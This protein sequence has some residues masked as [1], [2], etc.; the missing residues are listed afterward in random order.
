MAKNKEIMKCS[1]IEG[2]QRENRNRGLKK[3]GNKKTSWSWGDNKLTGEA[4]K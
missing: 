4:E 2:N 3:T 1:E